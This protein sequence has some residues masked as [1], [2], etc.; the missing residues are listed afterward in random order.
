MI[1]RAPRTAPRG[2]TL[3]FTLIELMVSL[4]LGL[5]VT[6]AAIAMFLANKRVYAT[7]E[8][9]SRTQESVRTAYELMSRD[10]RESAATECEAG[11]PT[12][13]L[14]NNAATL[15]YTNFDSPV[16]GYDGNQG[17][18]LPAEGFGT[19]AGNR[20]ANTDALE[21]KSAVN[22]GI[23]VTSH[24]QGTQNITLNTAAH[25]FTSGDIAVLCD[26]DHGA[27]VQLKTAS[28]ASAVVNHGTGTVAPGNCATGVGFVTP[29]NCAAAPAYTF[30]ANAFL[31]KLKAGRWYI[32]N[33]RRGPALF[34]AQ[35]INNGGTGVTVSREEIAPGVTNMQLQ[36]LL[37]GATNYVDA[38]AVTAAQWNSQNVLAV[39]VQLTVLGNDTTNGGEAVSRLLE[40][41]VTLRNRV[42]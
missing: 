17:F 20:I 14:I 27:I 8:N 29:V 32:G 10:M 34:Y 35:M 37:Q 19:A 25:G 24:V 16:R 40:H 7:T 4:L 30:A 38:S 3:G 2:R 13:N 41:T 21:V 9:L 36:Y 15:W 22:D 42:P 31:A 18:V 23:A 28:S 39:R 26:F 12:V 33:G 5:I 6:G 1:R 11:L